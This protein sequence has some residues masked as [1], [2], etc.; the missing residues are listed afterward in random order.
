MVHSR[1]R[2]RYDAD[3]LG[4]HEEEVEFLR[5]QDEDYLRSVHIVPIRASLLTMSSEFCH[6]E[7]YVLFVCLKIYGK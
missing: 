7:T 5:G 6:D 3:F 1:K 4:I 2:K